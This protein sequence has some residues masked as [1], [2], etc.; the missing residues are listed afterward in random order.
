MPKVSVIIPVYNVEQ[1]LNRCIDS[2]L[3][4]TYKDFEIILVDDGSTDKSGEI[5]DVYAEKDSRITVIHKENG[6][7]SDARNFGIDA[8]RGDFLTFLDSDDYF[9]PEYLEILVLNAE[10]RNAD[11]AICNY[12][13]NRNPEPSFSAA[14]SFDVKEMTA[15]QAVYEFVTC[16][17]TWEFISACA[18]IYKSE[19][20][21]NIRFSVGKINE[22][23]FTT[24]KCYLKSQKVIMC[25]VA[26]YYIFPSENSITRR[27]YSKKNLDAVT[28]V[29]E[30]REYFKSRDE[31]L[32]R[33]IT[34]K[35]LSV[36]GVHYFKI[37][38]HLQDK[39]LCGG[40][41]Q[42]IKQIELEKSTTRKFAVSVNDYADAFIIAHPV[43]AELYYKK[44]A[45][46]GKMHLKG[47]NKV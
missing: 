47:K 27:T 3:N 7:L 9:H 36:Y 42:K 25:P 15:E 40:L 16:N 10:R 22:D 34:D 13:V 46:L 39:K 38:K 18:K 35:L 31:R 44:K 1:Y 11:I 8:A 23:N 33:I 5:C 2:V 45:L 29:E 24:W 20:F 14:E 6:G 17:K 32:Y 26:L 28:A 19:I 21:E 12:T 4:Q 37:K 30:M 43:K 41:K